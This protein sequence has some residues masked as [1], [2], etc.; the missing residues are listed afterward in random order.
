MHALGLVRRKFI[1]DLLAI[2]VAAVVGLL[3]ALLLDDERAI[4]F[5]LLF[6]CVL[7]AGVGFLS[8]EQ[9]GLAL[10][11]GVILSIGAIASAFLIGMLGRDYR[12]A[13]VED[14]VPLLLG[15][16]VLM[17]MFGA[18][19]AVL[20]LPSTTS[21]WKVRDFAFIFDDSYVAVIGLGVV[22]L[23]LI[24]IIT[25]TIPLFAPNIDE[26]RFTGG[27]GLFAPVFAFLI[28]GVQWVLIS[29]LLVWFLSR[30]KP[31]NIFLWA[32]AVG[33]FVTILIAS[34]S[35]ALLVPLTIIVAYGTLRRLSFRQ[36]ASFGLAAL[37][38]LGL[39]GQARIAGSDPTG[40][41]RAFLESYGYGDG[42]TGVI[43]Q[44][45]STG[46]FVLSR[47]LDQMPE[48]QEFQ[49][50]GFLT[51]EIRAYLPGSLL[52]DPKAPDVWVS[53][54][55]LNID[56]DFGSPPTLVGGLYIDWGLPGV[57]IGCLLVGFLLTA[58]YHWARREGTLG[59]LILYAYL[60]SYVMLSAYSFL[61]LKPT[62][63]SVLALAFLL[64]RFERSREAQTTSST[65]AS[66][67][68]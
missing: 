55:I 39:A 47:V 46:P 21:R 42:P 13:G 35:I 7:A 8:R 23:A 52:G 50:G 25:G 22:L 58:V 61:S 59:S 10:G 28:G 4:G 31:Q 38:L 16:S 14:R 30:R 37:L 54:E 17:L 12:I 15:V 29:G 24:N 18:V 56:V 19:L 53:Q 68:P 20:I 2:A 11:P 44:S 64:H 3:G 43:I 62:M 1:Y 41:R 60:T 26:A 40:E 34:R 48:V 63:L 5:A 51:A 36:L 6:F 9:I 65:A 32:M 33:L 66:S 27:G 57:I 45:A 67:G 49:H